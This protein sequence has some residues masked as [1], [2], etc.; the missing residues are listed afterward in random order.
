[1]TTHKAHLQ[2]EKEEE[3]RICGD[4][5]DFPSLLFSMEL[6][7]RITLHI[8]CPGQK[9]IFTKNRP[10]CPRLW[11]KYDSK[12]TFLAKE[13]NM[14]RRGKIQKRQP[15]CCYRHHQTARAEYEPLLCS[16][17]LIR[18]HPLIKLMN[19]FIVKHVFIKHSF[20]LSN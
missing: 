17:Q 6:W 4:L 2:T 8:S 3:K 18:A 19:T 7:T 13:R 12:L 1:M 15:G 14:K 5:M 20:I 9:C 11:D 16:T 10:S